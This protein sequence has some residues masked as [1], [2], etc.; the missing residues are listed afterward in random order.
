MTEQSE[1]L[2]IGRLIVEPSLLLH[3][4]IGEGYF[5]TGVNRAVFKA[6]AEIHE[7]LRDGDDLHN[8]HQIGATLERHGVYDNVGGLAKLTEYYPALSNSFYYNLSELKQTFVKRKMLMLFAE[9]GEKIKE[10][11][12][13]DEVI[14]FIMPKLGRFADVSDN[15][16]TLLD[17]I[18]HETQNVFDYL[19]AKARG[20]QPLIGIPT[21]IGI[22]DG[23]ISGLPVGVPSVVAARPAE[24]KST[25]A[26]NIANNCAKQGLGVHLFS[27]EDGERSFSQRM[28]ALRGGINLSRIVQ[29]KLSQDERARIRT[30]KTGA[31]DKIRIEKAHGYTAQRIARAYRT[32]KKALGTKLIIV[33]YL[34]LMPGDNKKQ[35]THEQLEENMRQLAALAAEEDIAL[36]VL[37]QLR[38]DAQGKEPALNDMRG[39]GG[40]EQIGKLI[41]A[42][43]CDNPESTDL[44]FIVLKNFQGPRGYVIANYNRAECAIS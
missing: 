25:V 19:E 35:H 40:I 43:H 38:R 8:V 27:Y 33:D 36:L 9:A 23:I 31:L 20:E 5:Q 11:G 24:G 44:K 3:V 37:S 26:L 1:D 10:G 16:S 32:H 18:K 14:D 13:T 2:V 34:Q 17:A 15:T 29:R 22:L 28:M 6:I 21:G 7:V 41:I 30:I 39:S 42:L 12:H 4:N